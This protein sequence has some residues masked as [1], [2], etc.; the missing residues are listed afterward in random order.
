MRIKTSRAMI[1]LLVPM[2]L[3]LSSLATAATDCPQ[4]TDL[5]NNYAD[6]ENE[7]N[8]AMG[9]RFQD[10]DGDGK[11]DTEDFD[12]EEQGCISDY[13]IEGGFGLPSM[14]DLGGLMDQACEAAD[15]YIGE[16]L[17][18][19]GA[20]ISSPLGLADMELGVDSYD[21][22]KAGETPDKDNCQNSPLNMSE[23][24][25]EIGLDTG[26]FIDDQFDKLP[27]VESE[28][29]DYE[30]EGEGDASDYNYGTSQKKK[31]KDGGLK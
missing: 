25:N 27:E 18:Q 19:F 30:F 28:Y 9:E 23:S 22:C 13:G 14:A 20:N 10:K 4:L 15:A 3:G 16:Q 21:K 2:F 6:V 7:I 17:S 29:T 11:P 24:T 12:L 31:V 26:G 8:R 1:P 5:R